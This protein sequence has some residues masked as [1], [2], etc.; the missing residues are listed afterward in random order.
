MEFTKYNY[1]AIYHNKRTDYG[2]LM[3]KLQTMKSKY[4]MDRKELDALFMVIN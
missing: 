3:A 4:K 2:L 1:N